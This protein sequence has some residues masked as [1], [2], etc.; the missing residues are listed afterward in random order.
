MMYKFTVK[1]IRFK[2]NYTVTVYHSTETA[3]K[4]G[5]KKALEDV[6][7]YFVGE[8]EEVHWMDNDGDF[9]IM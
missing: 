5:R 9:D 3:A 2:E 4:N 1:G 8:I 6:D 7:V